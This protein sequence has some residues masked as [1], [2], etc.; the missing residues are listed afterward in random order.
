VASKSRP[1][2]FHEVVWSKPDS[3]AAFM[4]CGCE[5]GR[6]RARMGAPNGDRPCRHCLAVLAA[7]KNDG[8]EP[9]KLAIVRPSVFVD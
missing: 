3:T 1:G 7:E 2:M 5:V 4:A 6:H 8:S 9:P